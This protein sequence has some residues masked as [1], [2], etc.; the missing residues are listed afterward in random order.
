MFAGISWNLTFILII[1]RELEW[2]VLSA[3]LEASR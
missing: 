2:R 3:D 1:I